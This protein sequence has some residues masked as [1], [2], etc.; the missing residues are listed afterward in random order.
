MHLR[1][2]PFSA[3]ALDDGPVELEEEA[4]EQVTDAE[5]DEDHHRDDSGDQP[6]HRDQL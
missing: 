5:E 6:H 4:S 1:P 3:A 2:L